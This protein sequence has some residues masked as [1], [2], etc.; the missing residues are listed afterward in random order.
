MLTS[1]LAGRCD[2]LIATDVA[3]AAVVAAR[4]RV[5]DRA[6]VRVELGRIPDQWPPGDFDLI[7]LSEVGYYCDLPDLRRVLQASVATLTP[8]GVLVACHWRHPVPEYPLSGDVVHRVLADELRLGLLAR[9]EEEDF[10]LEVYV[11]PPVTSVARAADL[12]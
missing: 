5:S 1:E 10:L 12:A 8:D 4:S 6:G 2:E 3:E 7:V 11:R 9:H